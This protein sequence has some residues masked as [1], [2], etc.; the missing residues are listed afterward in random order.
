MIGEK[1][2]ER[3][4]MIRLVN[5][6]QSEVT[7]GFLSY[8]KRNDIMSMCTKTNL[9]GN[10]TSAEVDMFK[11]Q[12]ETLKHTVKGANIDVICSED[13]DMIFKKYFSASFNMGDSMGNSEE[14]SE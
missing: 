13:G 7:I 10:S 3:K 4:E 12:S 5:G 6:Q 1:M 8:Q 11:M 9:V 14:T 2:E